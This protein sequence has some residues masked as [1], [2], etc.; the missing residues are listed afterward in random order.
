LLCSH[1]LVAANPNKDIALES[2]AGPHKI[3]HVGE[4]TEGT[5]MQA[6]GLKAYHT[7]IEVAVNE[8]GNL[9]GNL[10]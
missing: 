9:T 3:S 8:I 7:R 4:T 10:S 5:F 6:F 2:Q 1:I